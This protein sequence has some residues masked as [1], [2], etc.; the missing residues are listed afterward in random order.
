M[1]NLKGLDLKKNVS[2]YALRKKKRLRKK[3]MMQLPR[4][5]S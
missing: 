3:L 1:N 4:L 5:K 2:K